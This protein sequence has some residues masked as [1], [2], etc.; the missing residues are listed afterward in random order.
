LVF[1]AVFD[2]YFQD[3]YES[4]KHVLLDIRKFWPQMDL[5]GMNNVWIVKPSAQSRGRGIRLINKLDMVMEKVNPAAMKESR[6]V[7]Q[8]YIGELC[9]LSENSDSVLTVTLNLG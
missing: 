4:A 6:Y 7:V 8:K 9:A 1:Q 2:V 5:D 3:L